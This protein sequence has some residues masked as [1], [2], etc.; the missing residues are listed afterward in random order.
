M[1]QRRPLVAEIKRNSLDDG[2]GI[3]SIVFFKGC[4]L[5]C[6]WCH[7]PECIE[8]GPELL[9]RPDKCIDCRECSA[10]CP[11]GAIG[12]AGPG[13][14]DRELCKPCGKC[15]DECPTEALSLVGKYYTSDELV[16]E[17]L[18]DKAFYDNSGG[19]VTL[20]G[21]EPTMYMDYSAEVARALKER[22]VS[23][24][25]ETC[26]DF[27]WKDFERKLLPHID[28]VYV[29]IKLMDDSEHKKFTA[30]G[31][32]RIKQNIG[33]LIAQKSAEILVRIPLIPNATSTT[34]N[35]KAIA[36]WMKELGIKRVALLPYNPLWI[37]KA[38]GIGKFLEYRHEKWM[39]EEE[40]NAVKKIF[41]EFDPEG[42]L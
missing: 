22:G 42:H 17:L 12:P 18:L 35:L 41:K 4:P 9:F 11:T 8:P 5:S 33:Q 36:V 6:V 24:C 38:E 14:I 32:D 37:N 2:P 23:V 15:A 28:L 40:R 10:V 16:K 20:S 3:R 13:A 19:G 26:G 7:N 34:A 25:V 27:K 29:D 30:R 1:E 31:V 21:G 39:S